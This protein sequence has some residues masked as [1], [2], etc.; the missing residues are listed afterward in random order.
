VDL[1]A[2]Y[3]PKK[4]VQTTRGKKKRKASLATQ[5]E[6]GGVFGRA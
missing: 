5:Q 4:F 2:C 6:E 1:L 3:E